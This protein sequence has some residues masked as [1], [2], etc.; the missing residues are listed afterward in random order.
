MLNRLLGAITIASLG[1][2]MV[3][4][5]LLGHKPSSA[6][7][8]A[9]ASQ[10]APVQLSRIQWEKPHR[11]QIRLQAAA[12]HP[13]HPLGDGPDYVDASQFTLVD[14]KSATVVG[15]ATQHESRPALSLAKL[16]IADYV[17]EHGTVAEQYEALTMV[18]DSADTTAAELYDAYPEAIDATAKKYGL[19]STTSSPLGWGY[20]RTSTYDVAKFITSLHEENPTHPILVAM[21][22]STPVAADG[23]TQD[24]GTAVLPG[25]VGSK[26]GWSNEQEL[27][28]SVSFGRN[29]V[30][31]AAVTGS[32]A[33]LTSYVQE[34][35]VL[36]RPS[37]GVQ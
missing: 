13:A 21:S 4:A 34:E 12:A 18:A 33:D 8:V 11:A 5:A 9:Q 2:I 27:H 36:L 31:A 23:T 6:P 10:V 26:W 16:Y 24:F 19:Y 1:G 29:Y 17:L 14:L 32:A 28:S 22:Q 35:T 15:S 37:W 25:V 3:M 20:A 7:D 30:V